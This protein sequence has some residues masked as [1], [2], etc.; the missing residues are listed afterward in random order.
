MKDKIKSK[1]KKFFSKKKKFGSAEVIVLTVSTLIISLSMGTF[2]GYRFFGSTNKEN[3]YSTEIQQFIENYQYIIDNYYE[4]VDEEKLI[5]GAI[6][7]VLSALGDPFSSFIDQ[8]DSL[9]LTLEGSFVGIGVEIITN[10]QGN[11]QIRKIFEGSPAEKS[12]LLVGDVITNVN[13]QDFKNKVPSELSNYIKNTNGEILVIVERNGQ[14]KTFKLEKGL[15]II[16]SVTSDVY[17]NKGKKTGYIKVDVFSATTYNQFKTEL[18]KI[19]KS[20]IDSLIIDLR[21][22]SGGHLSVVRDITSL[23]LNKDKIL[24]QTQFKEDIEKFY[25]SG[26][27]DKDYEIVLLANA[28]S[29]SASELMI[30][31]LKDNLGSKIV[32]I[33]T[34]GKGTVQEVQDLTDGSKYKFTI[35]KWLTPKGMWVH[36]K[37]IVPDYEVTLST[38]YLSN[39]TFENDNQLQK[40][41]E[42]IK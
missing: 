8:S 11:V 37:G 32:G 28:E 13:G 15:V 14:A 25:S 17:N 29:A 1:F 33:K 5:D 23:F 41:L 40:A 42:I 20:G 16:K 9:N 39:P 34:F 27:V 7:G 21:N 4:E 31:A 36:G 10:E 35:K 19:E 18:T 38:D 6:K 3:K 26:K 24:Y 2:L 22:N 30:A 12:G